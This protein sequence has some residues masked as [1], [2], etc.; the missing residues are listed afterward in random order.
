MPCQ[1]KFLY[2]LFSVH[3]IANTFF[4]K[5][6]SL[7]PQHDSKVLLTLVN[8]SITI[9][10][11]QTS[12]VNFSFSYSSELMLEDLEKFKSLNFFS[13]HYFFC[14]LFILERVILIHFQLIVLYIQS[15]HIIMKFFG[16]RKWIIIGRVVLII[17]L[18]SSSCFTSSK[19][20]KHNIRSSSS[21]SYLTHFLPSYPISGAYCLLSSKLSVFPSK[22]GSSP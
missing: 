3:F 2:I 4:I 13:N 21:E 7:F 5:N 6:I 14:Q 22:E 15:L 9:F 10:K 1:N 17:L 18:P 16:C 19:A 11:S 8:F 12:F 20:M